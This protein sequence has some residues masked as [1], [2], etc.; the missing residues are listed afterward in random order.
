MSDEVFEVRCDFNDEFRVLFRSEGPGI[1]AGGGQAG[2]QR[3]GD[4]FEL[5]EEKRVEPN[6]TFALV[7]VV[8]LKSEG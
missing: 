1:V 2:V 4:G 7:Q 3:W 8:E 5:L 6:E